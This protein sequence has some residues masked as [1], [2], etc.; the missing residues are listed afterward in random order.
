MNQTFA[1]LTRV[2]RPVFPTV[3][4]HVTAPDATTAYRMVALRHPGSTILGM[5]PRS[6]GKLV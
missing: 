4:I 2:T 1:V 5:M 3:V 6:A